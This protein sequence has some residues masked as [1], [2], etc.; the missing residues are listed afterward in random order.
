MAITRARRQVIVFSSFDPAQLRAEETSSVGVKHLRAY[1]DLAQQGPGALGPLPAGQ[2]LRVTDRHRE[3]VA[4][5]LRGR[6]FGVQTEVGLSDFT[7]DLVV[8][9]GDRPGRSGAGGA[10]GRTRV[11]R[12]SDRR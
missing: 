2:R 3:E 6:G 4:E 8:A 11:G 7:I 5:G 12:P 9:P 1:L 10:A